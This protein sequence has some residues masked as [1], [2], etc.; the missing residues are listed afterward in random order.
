MNSTLVA[1]FKSSLTPSTRM[2]LGFYYNW[3]SFRKSRKCVIKIFSTG[4][5]FHWVLQHPLRQKVV[6]LGI[7]VCSFEKLKEV[8][9][10]HGIKNPI[11]PFR[12]IKYFQKG[13]SLGGS[14]SIERTEA[15]KHFK[16]NSCFFF[17]MGGTVPRLKNSSGSFRG[18]RIL[19][20]CSMINNNLFLFCSQHRPVGIPMSHAL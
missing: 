7:R 14:G 6:L 8:L 11:K 5:P 17:L 12:K 3:L 20:V 10:C 18:H 15:S 1:V 19:P 4:Q 16:I 2:N 13:P 9:D